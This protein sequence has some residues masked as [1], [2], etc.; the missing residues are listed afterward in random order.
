MTSTPSA[1]QSIRRQVHTSPLSSTSTCSIHSSRSANHALGRSISCGFLD[2]GYRYRPMAAN[3]TS[4]PGMRSG[5]V[6]KL[7]GRDMP[8]V[9]VYFRGAWYFSGPSTIGSPNRRH[10]RVLW[11][12]SVASE[13]G[14]ETK[15]C[16][17]SPQ[18]KGETKS[19]QLH[20]ISKMPTAIRLRA[21]Y[22][23]RIQQRLLA[24]VAK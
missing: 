24:I 10:N 5:V 1:I 7:K 21:S 23:P 6:S 19:F 20:L 13:S 16:R 15:L 4:A 8:T 11:Y 14:R 18:S 2:G 9:F 17:S 12:E 3:A 22:V